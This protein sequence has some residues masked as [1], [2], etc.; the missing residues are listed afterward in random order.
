MEELKIKAGGME[1]NVTGEASMIK[2]TSKDFYD[3]LAGRDKKEI[4]AKKELAEKMR[5]KVAW[6]ARNFDMAHQEVAQKQ[7]ES[8]AATLRAV[9]TSSVSWD[10]LARQI[11]NGDSLSVGDKV[12]FKLKNG[13][14]VTVVVVQETEEFVRF[15]SVDCVGGEDVSWNENDSNKGGIAESDVQKYLNTKL[16]ELLP[17]D[18]QSVISDIRRK[19]MDGDEEK[20]YTTKLFLPAASEVFD[21][22]N[23]Y[24]DEG[25]YEQLEYYKDRRNRMKG[26]AKGEYMCAWWLASVG[27]GNSTGA[28]YVSSDGYA[29]GWL[30]SDVSRVPLCFCIKKS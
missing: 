17:D 27:S 13:E 22:D 12:D 4:E 18:L 23:C 21:E 9:R 26:E 6:Y 25:L 19:Y 24:G 28:C 15:E 10:E 8:G 14:E 2:E 1:L 16:W 7:T 3:Y 5:E 29:S 20:E 11:K 30:A